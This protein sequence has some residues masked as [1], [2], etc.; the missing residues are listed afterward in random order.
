MKGGLQGSEESNIAKRKAGLALLDRNSHITV[1]EFQQSKYSH[2]VIQSFTISWA[3]TVK[4]VTMR[5][6]VDKPYLRY[7]PC[8]EEAHGY[9]NSTFV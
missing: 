8:I 5:S 6:M 3:S 2:S 1:A 4:S 9:R 7:G